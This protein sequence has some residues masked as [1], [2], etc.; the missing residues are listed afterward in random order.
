[1]K[2]QRAVAL[3]D[4]NVHTP[5]DE[6]LAETKT[7]IEKHGVE[8]LAMALDVCSD[9]SVEASFEVVPE[10]LK[11]TGVLVVPGRGF[12]PSLANGVRISFGPLVHDLAKIESGIERLGRFVNGGL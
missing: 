11:A 1:M 10:A 6:A 8:C 5:P 9:A 3:K 12:G 4:Q 2:S 7:A